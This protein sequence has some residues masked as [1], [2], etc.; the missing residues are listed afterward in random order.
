MGADEVDEAVELNT[1]TT[2]N[3][4]FPWHYKLSRSLLYDQL[5]KQALKDII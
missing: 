2:T 1:T 5:I 4:K 3:S